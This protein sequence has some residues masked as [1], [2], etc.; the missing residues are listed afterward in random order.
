MCIRDRDF[1]F[2]HI[3]ESCLPNVHSASS[4]LVTPNL[5]EP[6]P[7]RRFWRQYIKMLCFVQQCALRKFCI[8]TLFSTKMEIFGRFLTGQNFGS[9]QALTYTVSQ[10]TVQNCFCQ[11]F[12][13]CPPILIVFGR[14]MAKR[15]KLFEMHSFSTL[16]NSRDHTTLLNSDVLNCH[17]SLKVV[18][19]NKLSNDLIYTQ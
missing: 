18:F 3:C 13:K 16:P 12:V 2:P 8:F 1:A 19:C 14:M 5:L 7:L 10:K 17:I 15:L 9:K 4:F 11:N 6:G